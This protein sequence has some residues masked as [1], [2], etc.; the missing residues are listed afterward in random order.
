LAEV[1]K[2]V[3][4]G[5][6]SRNRIHYL[7]VTL[8]SLS[9]TRLPEAVPLTV[10]DDASDTTEARTYYTTARGTGSEHKWPQHAMWKKLGLDV[11]NKSAKPPVGL[12][13]RVGVVRLGKKPAGV[14]NASCQAV[15]RM[16]DKYPDAPG[17]ILLQDDV[18]F[19]EDWYERL[20][21]V[22]ADE[23]LFAKPLAILSGLHLN[24]KIK[25]CDKQRVREGG[26]TAQCLYVTREGFT[27]L[28]NFFRRKHNTK[29]KFDDQLKKAASRNGLWAGLLVPFVCQHF[30]VV[31]LVRPRRTWHRGSKGRIGF[32]VNP[33]YAMADSVKAFK[34]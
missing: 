1:G 6:I 2:L 8:R 17:V 12:R 25:N 27:T 29:Q 23:L 9:A 19:K 15:C 33:P 5:I 14:V 34:G 24:K 22:A 13:G 20:T 3:P 31:S 30:G 16:F 28:D 21:Q 32:Y 10:F 18:I 11:I 26:I 4:I 7:D